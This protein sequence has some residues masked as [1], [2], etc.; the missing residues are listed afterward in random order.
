MP[1]V[2][3]YLGSLGEKPVDTYYDRVKNAQEKLNKKANMFGMF[4]TQKP[5][6]KESKESKDLWVYHI[7]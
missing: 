5:Q 4:S 3:K 7:S 6:P 1:D 2:R